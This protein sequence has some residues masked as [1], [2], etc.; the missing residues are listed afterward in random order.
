MEVISDHRTLVNRVLG[1][2][3]NPE[4]ELWIVRD[5]WEGGFSL[6]DITGSGMLVSTSLLAA[7]GRADTGLTSSPTCRPRPGGGGAT[8]KSRSH[9]WTWSHQKLRRTSSQ[10]PKAKP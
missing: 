10:R 2:P 5:A 7:F 3:G 8:K 4:G 6:R 9:G 1:D